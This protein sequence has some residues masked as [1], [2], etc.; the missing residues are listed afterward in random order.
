MRMTMVWAA[1]YASLLS[2]VKI[3]K[4]YVSHL[5]LLLH[6]KTLALSVTDHH[7]KTTKNRRRMEAGH[8]TDKVVL[9]TRGRSCKLTWCQAASS[10]KMTSM[11]TSYPSQQSLIPQMMPSCNTTKSVYGTRYSSKCSQTQRLMLEH[12]MA[13]LF[14]V[15]AGVVFVPCQPLRQEKWHKVYNWRIP[16]IAHVLSS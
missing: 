2:I 7:K 5:H 14:A 12:H 10:S 16:E 1:L 8:V 13:F 4:E 3:K 15:F 11:W 6:L 9:A